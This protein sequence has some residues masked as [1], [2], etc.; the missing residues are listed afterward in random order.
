M[1]YLIRKKN[2][3]DFEKEEIIIPCPESIIRCE[4]E[5][6]MQ[7]HLQSTVLR[8]L[9]SFRYVYTRNT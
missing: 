9:F 8:L 4:L 1:K 7:P 5:K 3:G 6:Q 2:G